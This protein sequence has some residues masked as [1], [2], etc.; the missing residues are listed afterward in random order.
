MGSC[1]TR[2]YLLSI[3]MLQLLAIIERQIF[4]FLGYMWAPILANFFQIIFVIFGFFGGY[5]FSAKYLITYTIWT[6]LWVGWNIFL[7][8]FY[9][10]VGVLNRDS[11]ILNLGTGSI[12]WFEVNGYGC[13]PTFPTNITSEDPYRL[14]RPEYVEGCLLEYQTIEVIHSSVQ[15][16]FAI[17]GL[18]GAMCLAQVFFD[19]DDRSTR[20]N[21][22]SKKKRQ[23][24][25]SIEFSP[26]VNTILDYEHES[27]RNASSEVSP[28]PMTPRRV[29]RRSVMTRGTNSRQST[30]SRRSHSSNRNSMRSSRRTK[31]FQQNPV[32]KLM[33][34]QHGHSDIST[35]IEGSSYHQM[36]QLSRPSKSNA[37]FQ[38]HTDSQLTKSNLKYLNTDTLTANVNKSFR[39]SQTF[40]PNIV[41]DPIYYNMSQSTT[42][43]EPSWNSLSSTNLTVH[44]GGGGGQSEPQGHYN[45]TY[46]HSTPNLATNNPEMVDEVYNNRP[47]S[48]RSSYSNFHG[49]RAH[50]TNIATTDNENVFVGLNSMT[51]NDM[52]PRSQP[53][54]IPQLPSRQSASRESIRSIAFLNNGPPAY[55]LNYHTPPDSE[56]T[57]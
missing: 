37:T 16:F 53:M 49:A 22:K 19:D 12:S 42:F 27:N 21:T 30:N 2:H 35:P 14:V 46:Q 6:L 36:H 43:F 26:P 11:D 4:D 7:I 44:G 28:K 50:S 1:T 32:T 41:P 45:P 17:L 39:K 38:P 3:C 8:C 9:L 31:H 5:Q 13:V 23:S 54:P 51:S 48:V 33:D 40:T 18:I 20:N 10:N 34:Y 25:Y 24:L 57:M 56:T 47:P 55:N 29:K 52:Q 15:L